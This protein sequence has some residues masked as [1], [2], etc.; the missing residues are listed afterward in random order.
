MEASSPRRAPHPRFPPQSASCCRTGPDAAGLATARQAGIPATAIDHRDFGRDR[1]AHEA[2]LD[3]VLRAANIEVVCLAGYMR[4][5]T[6]VL[7]KP[8]KAACS[9]IH[10]SLLPPFPAC[11]PMPERWRLG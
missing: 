10:P 9:N 3:A 5:L 7:V 4:L 11:T 1:A 6:P 2:A 8:G